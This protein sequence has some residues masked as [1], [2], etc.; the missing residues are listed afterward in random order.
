MVFNFNTKGWLAI[1]IFL[2]ALTVKADEITTV[3]IP[4]TT[5]ALK[6][7]AMETVWVTVVAPAPIATPTVPM[8]PSYT[9][10]AIFKK[11]MLNVT[12]EYRKNHD[13]KPLKWNDTLAEI[14]KGWAD[15]CI[16]KHSVSTPTILNNI[17]H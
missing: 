5:I 14:S 3:H 8:H 11:D 1:L 17:Q 7:E 15:K 13:A 6:A 10:A 12:N 9:D 4:M 16:W 2:T